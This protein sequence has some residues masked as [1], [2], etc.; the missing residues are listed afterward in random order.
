[1]NDSRRDASHGA[2][3]LD[4]WKRVSGRPGGKW[5]FSRFVGRMAPY[6]GTINALV[7]E[8]EPGRAV[9][10]LK[11]RRGVRNHLRSV[12]A[13]ALANLGELASGLAASAAMPVG[14]RGIP[15]AITI[16]YRRKARGTLTATGIADLPEVTE[17]TTAQVHAEIRDTSGAVVSTVTVTWTLER[18]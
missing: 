10:E 14:V 5:L 17:P 11:D 18:V 6:T 3:L 4:A 8:L 1:M 13:I 16:E 9:V 12:H 7:R 2:R 15:T